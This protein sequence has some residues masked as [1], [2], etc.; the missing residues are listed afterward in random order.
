MTA[1]T[2][3]QNMPPNQDGG[4]SP[5]T[6]LSRVLPL[7]C[8]AV[9]FTALA[10]FVYMLGYNYHAADR[11]IVLNLLLA[12]STSFVITLLCAFTGYGPARLTLPAAF[13]CFLALMATFSIGPHAR[14]LKVASENLNGQDPALVSH[15]SHTVRQNPFNLFA[16]TQALRPIANNS[17]LRQSDVELFRQA[18]QA[19]LSSPAIDR[20][21]ANG[22]LRPDDKNELLIAVLHNN[23]TDTQTLA[24]ALGLVDSL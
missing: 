3:S 21:L 1:Q 2:Y 9:S 15:V 11:W 13:L 19:G 8:L 20:V 7:V 12:G 6:T 17:S 24:L 22:F 14:A 18:R 5:Q 10:G 23:S 16:I 4:S